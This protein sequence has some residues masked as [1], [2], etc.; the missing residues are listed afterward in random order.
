[1]PV[2]AVILGGTLITKRVSKIAILG[3]ISSVTIGYFVPVSSIV[4]TEK[5]VTSEPV[6]LVVGTAI[7]IKS[8][9]ALTRLPKYNIAFPASIADPPPTEIIASAFDSTK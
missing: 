8:L 7:N 2:S 6:P 5:F 4:I 1:M 9:L 3:C